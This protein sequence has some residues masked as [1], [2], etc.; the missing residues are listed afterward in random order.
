MQTHVYVAMTARWMTEL[1]SLALK[2]DPEHCPADWRGW[3]EQN[4]VEFLGI[5]LNGAGF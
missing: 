1:G 3:S 2:R 5:A 4:F